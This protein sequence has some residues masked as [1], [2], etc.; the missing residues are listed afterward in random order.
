MMS[1]VYKEWQAVMDMYWKERKRLHKEYVLGKLDGDL[2]LPE[3]NEG[4]NTTPHNEESDD[5]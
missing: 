4:G 3:I 5:E 1:D 2:A